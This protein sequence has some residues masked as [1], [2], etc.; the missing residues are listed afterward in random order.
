VGRHGCE[1][2]RIQAHRKY[3]VAANLSLQGVAIYRFFFGLVL[4]GYLLNSPFQMTEMKINKILQSTPGALYFT[5]RT[6]KI[7]FIAPGCHDIA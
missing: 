5:P 6:E 4:E 7:R 1:G 2:R 3:G